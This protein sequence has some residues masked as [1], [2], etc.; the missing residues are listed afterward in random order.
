M[1]DEFW[2]APYISMC[3]MESE[4]NLLFRLTVHIYIY[5]VFWKGNGTLISGKS[6]LVKYHNLAG[7]VYAHSLIFQFPIYLNS[8]S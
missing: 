2:E 7:L 3:F 1:G 4:N 8:S 6:R 5:I